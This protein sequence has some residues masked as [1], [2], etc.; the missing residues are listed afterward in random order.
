MMIASALLAGVLGRPALPCAPVWD[1]EADGSVQLSG[2]EAIIIWDAE[3]KR[4]HFIRSAQFETELGS[5][6][7][8][9]PTPTEPELSEVD[10]EIFDFPAKSVREMEAVESAE[11]PKSVEVLQETV[12]AGM[13]AAVLR[14]NDA[15]A[16]NGWLEKHGYSS[17]PAVEEWLGPYIDYGWLV[18]AFKLSKNGSEAQEVSSSAVR[19][20]FHTPK[21]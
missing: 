5:F 2:E 14:A 13:D 9:V 21:L 15:Q 6:G 19:M 12:V 3:R 18:T 1:E 8:L 4:Q 10:K 7:F 20:S 17:S 11:V 16:L